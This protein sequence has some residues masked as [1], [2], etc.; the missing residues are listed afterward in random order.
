MNQDLEQL[1]QAYSRKVYCYLLSLCQ[2]PVLAEDLMQDTFLKAAKKIDTF[3]ENSSLSSWLCAIAKNLY[4]DAMRKQKN[5]VALEEE[6]LIFDPNQRDLRI[7]SCLHD[8]CEPYREIIYLRI[9]CSMSFKE[10]GEILDRSDTWSR[11][12]FYR[13]KEKL[14]ALWLKKE[15]KYL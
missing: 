5:T 7:F 13:G 6:L 8:L 1:Y 9:F 12:M 15:G 3:K 2:N 10:I 14:R 4:Y 11:V